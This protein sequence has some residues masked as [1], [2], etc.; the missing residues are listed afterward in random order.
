MILVI[1]DIADI[2][3][4]VSK[5]CRYAR[6]EKAAIVSFASFVFIWVATRIVIFPWNAIYS[7]AFEPQRVVAMS[8]SYKFWQKFFLV[9]LIALY[10]LHVYW[11]VIIFKILRKALADPAG[12]RDSRESDSEDEAED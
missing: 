8:E 6:K 4:E 7:A 12:V 11:T 10:V 2:A 3:L 1:H 5:L 9:F